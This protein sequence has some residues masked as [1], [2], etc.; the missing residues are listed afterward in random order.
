MTKL[1][2]LFSV[3]VDVVRTTTRQFTVWY[4]KNAI[5][6]TR[7][8]SQLP[9]FPALLLLTKN[10]ARVIIALPEFYPLIFSSVVNLCNTFM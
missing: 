7:Q 10:E 6:I 9:A 3:V 2:L 8:V 1:P 4:C 5:S